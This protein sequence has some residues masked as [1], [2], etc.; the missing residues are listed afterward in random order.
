[1]RNQSS[2]MAGLVVIAGSI[3]GI[4]AFLAA[5]MAVF[6]SYDYVGAGICLL[7]SALAFGLLANAI[8]RN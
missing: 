6:D 3:V 2:I 8:F 1:M 7:A 4:A 5:I